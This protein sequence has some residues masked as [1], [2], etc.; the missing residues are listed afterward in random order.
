MPQLIVIPANITFRCGTPRDLASK[1]QALILRSLTNSIVEP[2]ELR[3]FSQRLYARYA[4]GRMSRLR[5]ILSHWRA[6]SNSSLAQNF[7]Y[8]IPECSFVSEISY[9]P[10]ISITRG[11]STHRFLLICETS[12]G[13]SLISP[14]VIHAQ[15]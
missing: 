15:D 8:R 4:Q 10:L 1:R 5:V 9:V 12:S 7:N 11:F 14:V 13:L 6:Y 3:S 2:L